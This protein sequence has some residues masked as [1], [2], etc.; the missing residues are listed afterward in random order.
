MDVHFGRSPNLGAVNLEFRS[1]SR[2]AYHI[3]QGL[4]IRNFIALVLLEP[5]IRAPRRELRKMARRKSIGS[6]ARR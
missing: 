4:Q 3:P 1:V 6:I 2:L 5:E